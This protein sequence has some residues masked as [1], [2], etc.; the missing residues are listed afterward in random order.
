[1]SG[2]ISLA[3]L[4]A[5][6]VLSRYGT[7][8]YGGVAP[9][10]FMARRGIAETVAVILV[11]F[12]TFPLGGLLESVLSGEIGEFGLLWYGIAAVIVAFGL[13]GWHLVGR[14]PQRGNAYLDLGEVANDAVPG[15]LDR[16]VA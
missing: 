10:G 2:L 14:I 1:M 16:K 4:V 15:H 7:R 5:A 12:I 13:V 9:Q 11:A 3:I 8:R 6:I